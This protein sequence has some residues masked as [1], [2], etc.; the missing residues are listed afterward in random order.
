MDGLDGGGRRAEQ[1]V[2]LMTVHASK[3]LEFDF[4]FVTG[5]EENLMPHYHS[6]STPEEVEEERRVLYVAMTRARKQLVLTHAAKRG[7]WGK[8]NFCEPSRF[9]DA[10]PRACKFDLRRELWAELPFRRR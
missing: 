5:V 2:K 6:L 3:G 8:M 4:V 10:L 7:R 1:P 9:L